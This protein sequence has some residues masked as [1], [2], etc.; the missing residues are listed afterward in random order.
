MP[1]RKQKPW[2]QIKP[3]I[4][5]SIDWGD[6]INIGLFDCWLANAG[7][8]A[9]FVGLARRASGE[10][11]GAGATWTNSLFGKGVNLSGAAGGYIGSFP[12][13]VP[14]PTTAASITAWAQNISNVNGYSPILTRTYGSTHS[15]PYHTFKLGANFA[16]NGKFNCEV[17]TATVS[18]QSTAA[19]NGYTDK[20]W[21]FVACTYD[22]V[23]VKL[24]INGLLVATTATTGAF[25]YGSGGFIRIGANA[26][27]A[28]QF[29]GNIDNLRF[30]HARALRPPEIRRL[31]GREPFAG[32]VEPRR[33]IISQ[34]P[35]GGATY[36][37]DITETDGIADTITG[38]LL[39]GGGASESMAAADSAGGLSVLPGTVSESV[40]P[41]DSPLGAL[42]EVGSVTETA[43]P[44]DSQSGAG[45]FSATS[46]ESILAGEAFGGSLVLVAGVG[47]SYSP[48][49]SLSGALVDVGAISEGIVSVDSPGAGGG[50]A[51]GSVESISAI[52]SVAGGLVLVA[53]STEVTALSDL[54]SSLVAAGLSITEAT[55]IVATASITGEFIIGNQNYFMVSV[56]ERYFVVAARPRDFIVRPRSR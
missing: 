48:S 34:V 19:P 44:S 20:V 53:S 30:Y 46:T 23:N 10:F 27:G 33:R 49:E 40:L 50:T 6:P 15:S 55:T 14:L 38:L 3:S 24:Y 7:A 5:A 29:M 41:A 56:K 13:N 4:G 26:S 31:Y 47:E 21:Y 12:A 16:G 25:V 18:D 52:D 37:G 17:S 36:Q 42:V 43:S 28:E 39:L 9:K 8:G 2:G 32:I 35:A 11:A 45:V 54:I 51:G 22:G 1:F